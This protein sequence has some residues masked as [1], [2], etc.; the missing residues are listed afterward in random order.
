MCFSFQRLHS[1][2]ILTPHQQ[3]SLIALGFLLLLSEKF[4]RRSSSCNTRK[5]APNE[6]QVLFCSYEI[7]HHKIMLLSFLLFL[8]S[9]QFLPS[10]LSKLSRK[11]RICSLGLY[12]TGPIS[13]VVGTPASYSRVL[14]WI[15]SVP[16]DTC[17]DSISQLSFL[18]RL[19]K[20]S[21]H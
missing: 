17:R 3:Y 6:H 12:F 2:R 21:I 19:F 15:Y 14:S 16:K 7:I 5:E 13:R 4:N 20:H 18:P 1:F 11:P 8:L 9:L 10:S